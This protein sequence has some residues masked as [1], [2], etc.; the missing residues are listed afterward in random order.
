MMVIQLF[1]YGTLK[2]GEANYAPYCGDH[3]LSA[4][5]V[6]TWGELYHLSLGYPGMTEGDRKVYGMLLTFANE[7]V[8]ATI[9]RLEDYQSDRPAEQNDYQ[10]CRLPIFN[11]SDRFQSEAWGYRMA[12]VKVHQ[13]RGI[14]IPSGWWTQG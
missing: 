1:V 11:L 5:K 7:K 9:D 2:P 3:V 13:Y 6:Y 12:K 10:R 4:E 14:L 8:L